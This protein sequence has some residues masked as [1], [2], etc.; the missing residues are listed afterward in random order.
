MATLPPKAHSVRASWRI[1]I[2]I[3]IEVEITTAAAAAAAATTDY[4][5][6]H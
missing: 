3:E 1:Q 6:L 2:E 4:I 5:V